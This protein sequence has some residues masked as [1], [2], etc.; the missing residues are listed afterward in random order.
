MTDTIAEENSWLQ[1][2]LAV[3]NMTHSEWVSNTEY[4]REEVVQIGKD[5][6]E[7]DSK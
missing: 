6:E 7:F 1:L 5:T 4:T 3:L 2:G